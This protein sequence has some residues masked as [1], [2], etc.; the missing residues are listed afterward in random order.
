MHDG[1]ELVEVWRSEFTAVYSVTNS[2]DYH[3]DRIDLHGP[4]EKLGELLARTTSLNDAITL[5]G[6]DAK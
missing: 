4:A 1:K 3:V 6:K 2:A 5:A